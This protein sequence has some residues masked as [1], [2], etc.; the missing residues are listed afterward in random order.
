LFVGPR[1]LSHDLGVPGN[2]HAPR[3]LEALDQVR[4]A[5]QQ[6]GKGCGL[7]VPNGSA[8]AEKL[9]QGWTFVGVASDSTLLASALT[10]ELDRARTGGQP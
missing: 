10:A 6:F 1:D 7:L 9:A 5:A 3:Y 8:A 2:V 4:S